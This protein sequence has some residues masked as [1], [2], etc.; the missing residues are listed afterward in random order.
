MTY[1]ESCQRN[2]DIIR[3]DLEL[4]ADLEQFPALNTI[5]YGRNSSAGR[6]LKNV[7]EFMLDHSMPVQI[8]SKGQGYWKIPRDKLVSLHGGH[9]M[10]WQGQLIFFR[11]SGLLK[12]T[13]PNDQTQLDK[14]QRAYL[15]ARK[16]GL[17]SPVFY[18]P[19]LYTPEV[20]RNANDISELFI[21]EGISLGKLTKSQVI[22]VLGEDAANVLYMDFRRTP[23]EDIWLKSY[24]KGLFSVFIER[25][26]Y[27]SIEDLQNGIRAFLRFN[28]NIKYIRSGQRVLDRVKETCIEL[29]CRYAPPTRAQTEKYC[30]KSKQWIITPIDTEHTQERH[31]TEH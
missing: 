27:L 5:L 26:G 9:K 29:G 17:Q 3:T 1:K 23:I 18:S 30:L 21:R 14:L 16:N 12:G 31:Y 24:L 11:A 13:V 22:K 15:N 19:V 7:L 28:N 4:L 25:Q 6:H 8:D 10:T 2:A 20:L